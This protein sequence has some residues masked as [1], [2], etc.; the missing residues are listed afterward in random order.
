MLVLHLLKIYYIPSK[1]IKIFFK[2][3]QEIKLTKKLFKKNLGCQ[4][5]IRETNS[6]YKMEKKDNLQ[7]FT[8]LGQ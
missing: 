1:S 6:D 8:F 7:I 3:P 4:M 2:K 5:D